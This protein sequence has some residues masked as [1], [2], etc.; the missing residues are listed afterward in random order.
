MEVL[1]TGAAGFIGMN[2]ARKLLDRGDTVI[3]YDSFSDYY[4]VSLKRDRAAVL[5]AFG[6]GFRM[7]E[8]DL[9]ERDRIA[10]LIK[11]GVSHRR[12]TPPGGAHRRCHRREVTRHAPKGQLL[13][14]PTE[15]EEVHHE[16]H[17]RRP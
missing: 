5:E 7:E 12:R 17:L 6:E 4:D 11:A 14:E 9:T 16:D 1:V 8:G 13:V 3:G 2:V 15:P 10:E